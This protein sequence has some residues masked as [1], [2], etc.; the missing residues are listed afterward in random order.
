MVDPPLKGSSL[1]IQRESWLFFRGL[2]LTNTNF[3]FLLVFQVQ[4][5]KVGR[6]PADNPYTL[7][8]ILLEEKDSIIENNSVRPRSDPVWKKLKTDH[9][10]E[11]TVHAIHSFVICNRGPT[12]GIKYELGLEPRPEVASDT[13]SCGS[14]SI[15]ES[16]DDD[17]DIC[18]DSDISNDSQSDSQVHFS[19][20]IPKETWAVIAPST[21]EY[22]RGHGQ[23][24]SYSKLQPGE[25]T[26]QLSD[27]LHDKTRLPCAWSFKNHYVA[28][29]SDAK[30]FLVVTGSCPC[31]GNL[32][33]RSP[34]P[35]ATDPDTEGI[36]V[37]V[38]ITG[39]QNVCHLAFRKAPI[40]GQERALLGERM[41][42]ERLSASLV[43]KEMAGATMELFENEPSS[44]PRLCTLRKLKSETR[45]KDKLDHDPIK[46]I[47]MLKF[48]N[49]YQTS[50]MDVGYIPFFVHYLL[51]EQLRLYNAYASKVFSRVIID[52]SGKIVAK[53]PRPEG[54]SGHIFLYQ[55]VI[56]LPGEKEGQVPVAQMLSERQNANAI[57]YWLS[58]WIRMGAALP[59]EVVCDFSPALIS[60]VCKAFSEANCREAYLDMCL[61]YLRD[62]DVQTKPKVIIRID[63]AHL[64]NLI[65]KWKSVKAMRKRSKQFF[66]R[67]IYLIVSASSLKETE[68]LVESLLI[69]ASNETEG[70]S[71][72]S[73]FPTPCENHK[74]RLLDLIGLETF[75]SCVEIDEEH[76][77]A[78]DEPVEHEHDASPPHMSQWVNDI[79]QRATHPDNIIADGARDNI[80]FSPAFR[81]AFVDFCLKL[82]LWTNLLA[83]TAKSPHEKAVGAHVESSFNDL[84]NR[85]ITETLRVDLFL[86]KHIDLLRSTMLLAS[87]L[88]FF[89]ERSSCVLCLLP[90]EENMEYDRCDQ[91]Q[92]RVHDDPDCSVKTTDGT[93]ICRKCLGKYSTFLP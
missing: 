22:S 44:V 66:L 67:S 84:K 81:T 31:G 10:L 32:T 33:L 91:C 21:V 76:S 50:I 68:E 41:V 74:Q 64:I 25:W 88:R 52:A 87:G 16:E 58:E 85:L 6:K 34:N 35:L 73:G 18:N 65:S 1:A 89:H 38:H 40:R 56:S 62:P 71:E 9:S 46:A 83:R 69:V 27:L 57:S 7:Q 54:M 39:A 77:E 80:M 5:K 17:S 86:K 90:E 49:P 51:A 43:R 60:A 19:L 82:P 28:T 55:I 45:S 37:E 20:H 63:I 36:N 29:S 72:S 30:F 79:F 53:I 26:R 61:A 59:R 92:T 11:S 8:R 42:R 3:V 75:P 23:R 93:W 70:I 15:A 2:Q 12:G 48:K 14:A 13:D 78:V 24:R 4:K 47:C